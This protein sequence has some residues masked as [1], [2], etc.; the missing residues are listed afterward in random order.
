MLCKYPISFFFIIALIPPEGQLKAVNLLIQKGIREGYIQ[1]DY[2]LIGH[3][4]A[5]GNI[6]HNIKLIY[7]IR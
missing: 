4:Q 2:K 3:R 6:I 1:A 7:P 5:R